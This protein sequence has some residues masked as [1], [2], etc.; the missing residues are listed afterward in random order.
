MSISILT[1]RQIAPLLAIALVVCITACAKKKQSSEAEI[2]A[3][4]KYACGL[5]TELFANS[6]RI[7][8]HDDVYRHYRRG[9]GEKM[10]HRLADYSWLEE[11]QTLRPGDI[12]MEPPDT[13]VVIEMSAD[14]AVVAYHTPLSLQEIWDREPYSIDRLRREDDHWVIV[15]SKPTATKPDKLPER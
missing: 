2:A 11:A 1:K 10:A 15:E 7:K 3:A 9:F 6:A 13:V 5:E 12:T 14:E 4:V 8:S